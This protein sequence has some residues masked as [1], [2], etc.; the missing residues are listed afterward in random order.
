MLFFLFCL[1]L[2]FLVVGAEL[3]V[4]GAAALAAAV[5]VSPLV[6]GL[7]VVAIGTSAPELAVSIQA[8][9]NHQGDLA[10]GNVVGSN[11]A[12]ILLIL[13]LAALISPLTV[14]PQLI[15]LDVPLMIAASALTMVLAWDGEISRLDGGLLTLCAIAYTAFTVYQSR[16]ESAAVAAGMAEEFPKP[17]E[18]LRATAIARDLLYIA[19]GL[20]GLVVGA[21]WIVDGAV[22]AATWLGVSQLVIGLTVVAIG[23]SLPEIAATLVAVSRG[24]R[25]MA[26]GNAV[27]SNLFNLF[28]VLGAAGLASATPI[29]VPANAQ[30]FDLPVM[31]AV[32]IACLPIFIAGRQIARWEAVLFL[33]YYVAY[34]TYLVLAAGEHTLLENLR[35]GMLYFVLPLTVVGL[36]VSLARSLHLERQ[37]RRGAAMRDGT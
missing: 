2:V 33:F 23:T 9:L 7:T 36:F 14:A 18:K 8:A 22:A 24:Q 21:N 34:V 11:I 10:L 19:L 12:N 35:I 25:D 13:G 20:V 6:I 15:R 27:G 31:C 30:V 37:A 5:G 28:G 32:A 29:P 4:R 1:G 17:P 16:R 3:V 26:V